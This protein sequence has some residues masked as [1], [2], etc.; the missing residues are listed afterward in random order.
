MIIAFPYVRPRPQFILRKGHGIIRKGDG[1]YAHLPGEGSGHLLRAPPPEAIN[2]DP[3]VPDSP[4]FA[5]MGSAKPHSKSEGEGHNGVGELLNMTA[6]KGKYGHAEFAHQFD[7]KEYLHHHG[8]DGIIKGVGELMEKLGVDPLHPKT[9]AMARVQQAIDK[10]NAR[11]DLDPRHRLP[12]VNST[13]WRKLV[14]APYDANYPNQT[15]TKDGRQITLFTNRGFENSP[16]GLHVESYANHFHKELD[17]VLADALKLKGYLSTN[18]PNWIKYPY[19]TPR[20]L[21]PSAYR[22]KGKRFGQGVGPGST[23]ARA[24]EDSFPE[25][26]QLEPSIRDV[27]SWEMLHHLPR[28]FFLKKAGKGAPPRTAIR[29]ANEHLKYAFDNMDPEKVPDIQVP[30]NLNATQEAE[31]GTA[32]GNYV[33]RNLRDVMK[34]AKG[35]GLNAGDDTELNAML[36]ELSKSPAFTF[37][38]GRIN[39]NNTAG[40]L[41][42]Q[43]MMDKIEDT[44]GLDYAQMKQHITRGDHI[45]L[46]NGTTLHEHSHDNA[47][48]LMTKLAIAG[49]D[50]DGVSILR[51]TTPEN[52]AD[53][54]LNPDT[55]DENLDHRRVGLQGVAD[56]LAAG[57]GHQVQRSLP[58]DIPTQPL[59]S[60]N[61]AGYSETPVHELPSH[62]FHHTDEHM[63]PTRMKGS[64]EPIREEGAPAVKPPES[65]ALQ[66][67]TPRQGQVAVQQPF[68]IPQDPTLASARGK[69]GAM[70][71]PSQVREAMR[72]I[73]ARVPISTKPQLTE[74]ERLFQ[75]TFGDPRQQLLSQYLRSLDESL[76]IGDRLMKAMEEMQKDEARMDASIIKHIPVR[77]IHIND[78]SGVNLI[79]KKMG[80]TSLDVRTIAHSTGDW[81][82]VSKQLD[83]PLDIVKVVK[84]S[85]GG[86]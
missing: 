69:I 85:M 9:G 6:R 40:N 73:G 16:A 27:Y 84:V 46:P 17:E 7:G 45:K 53:F 72:Q 54:R 3:N 14:A 43:F 50:E 31:N 36:N 26:A 80:L 35:V 15:K 74:Q 25:G 13:E 12:D 56:M 70:Q 86:I 78:E 21:H 60:R 48:K 37:M 55:D 59:Y 82:R 62:M 47:A 11:E 20:D 77:S 81:G 58:E 83:V 38:F 23:T 39:A 8:M 10:F 68:P 32:P 28:A 65:P 30:I 2:P 71:N 19:I 33:F 5:H 29:L 52:P 41:L 22:F 18:A 61:V 67:Q 75:Q 1:V 24:H 49:V 42:Y 57:F 63:L 76:P 79:A 34:K 66:T 64:G 44:E 4:A 51:N